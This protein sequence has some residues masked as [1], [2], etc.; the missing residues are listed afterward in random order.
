MIAYIMCFILFLVGLYGVITRRNLVKIA[1]SLSIMEISTFLFFA[2]VGYIDG[3]AAPIVNPADPA[4][5]YVDPLPQALVLT[6]IVIGLAT[7]AMM[8]AVI[9]RLYRKYG[10][11][12]IRE[13]R[14]LRG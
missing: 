12:D 1:V 4:K 2:L 5:V 13:I 10:T 3:G 11:F 7:T 6:A 9:I 8:M 14:N